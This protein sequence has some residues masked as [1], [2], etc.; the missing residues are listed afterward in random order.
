M[1]PKTL[2]IA[3]EMQSCP[4][5]MEPTMIT[6]PDQHY[7]DYWACPTCQC[8][9]RVHSRCYKRYQHRNSNRCTL[10]TV[11]LGGMDPIDPDNFYSDPETPDSD[12]EEDSE[13][14]PEPTIKS[15]RG[16]RKR[17]MPKPKAKAAVAPSTCKIPNI[18]QPITD[19]DDDDDQSG[20]GLSQDQHTYEHNN[21]TTTT[22]K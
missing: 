7:H 21:L 9:A 10:C 12:K 15:A 5:C 6:H 18:N 14:N 3:G 13:Y 17:K 8:S 11:N 20:P 16:K 2:K 1:G 19:S 4:I 22:S